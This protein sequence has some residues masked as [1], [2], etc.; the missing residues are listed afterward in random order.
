[1]MKKPLDGVT[2]LD[3]TQSVAGPY[4]TMLLGDLGADV[5]KVERPEIGDDTRSWGPPYW[6]E[7]ST[8]FLSLNRN[9]RSIA[10][11]MKHEEGERI[12]WDLVRRADVLVQNLRTGTFER[13][14]FGYEAVRVENPRIIYCSMTAYGNAGPMRGF[15][16]YDPL[17]Q[18]FGGLM[19]VTGEPDG[20]PVRV[21]TSI[22][23]MGMGMWGVIGTLGA[24]HNREHTGEGQLVEMSLYETALSWVPYQIMS[25]LGTG[26]VP[27]RHGSGTA[28]LAPYEAY[29]TRNGH[30]LIAAGNNSL[31]D[32]LCRVLGLEGLPGDPRFRD[33]PDRVRNREALFEIL[34]E[35]MR[36]DTTEAW[37]ERLWDAGVPCSPIRTMDQVVTD[38]QTE[39]VDILRRASH[40]R[41]EGYAEVG[42][43][44]SWDGTRPETRR[45]PPELGADTRQILREIGKSPEEIDDLLVEG[46]VADSRITSRQ[47]DS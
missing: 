38:P 15:P 21:G 42:I 18:A 29:P 39:A 3:V 33:N 27:K 17:M 6:N 10:L 28:M 26:E 9:K 32:K 14:G 7:E 41:I 30:I 24:L 40:P 35:R 31:W 16:G 4:C 19:S 22:M 13:L 37:M 43:P 8:T 23:D 44:V 45:V 12:M 5:I 34:V 1:L 46:A 36:Q 2:V 47:D 25:Y 20:A 11:D